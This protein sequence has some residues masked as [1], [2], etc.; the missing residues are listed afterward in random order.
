MY[1]KLQTVYIIICFFHVAVEKLEATH[2]IR[3]G[4]ALNFSVFYYEIA[5]QPEE[6]CKLAKKV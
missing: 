5:G 1:P 6:A 3:L 4:L 2:A